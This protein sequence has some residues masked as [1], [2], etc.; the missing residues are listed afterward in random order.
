MRGIKERLM[1]V[2]S[3][4]FELNDTYCYHLTRVKEGF[5]YGTVTLEDF[6]EFDDATIDDLA[7]D[8]IK[9]NS[10]RFIQDT[11]YEMFW[12]LCE[13]CKEE[14][15]WDS[16]R[17]TNL[18]HCPGC[19]RKITE[20]VDYVDPWDAEAED[21]KCIMPEMPY[22]PDCKYG[23]VEYP[24]WVETREDAYDSGCKWICTLREE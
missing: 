21:G 17:E 18:N 4:Y 16:P 13:Q 12:W 11:N 23:R 6:V 20:F 19:G 3:K 1:D 8:I 10:T 2:L 7:D 9:N 15:L 22:C 5:S 24:D 14:Y